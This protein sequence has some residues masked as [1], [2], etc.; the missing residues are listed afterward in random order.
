VAEKLNEVE[1]KGKK[2]GLFL[3][4]APA[5]RRRRGYPR[6]RMCQKNMNNLQI[7][8]QHALPGVPSKQKKVLPEMIDVKGVQVWREKKDRLLNGDLG[9]RE[10]DPHPRPRKESVY[11]KD[12]RACP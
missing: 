2:S 1:M 4:S 5:L 9:R 11:P 7:L 12:S 10:K 8:G 3:G 6:A